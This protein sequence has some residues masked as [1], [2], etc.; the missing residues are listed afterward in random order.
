MLKI[1]DIHTKNRLSSYTKFN[2]F[3]TGDSVSVIEFVHVVEPIGIL[4]SR[5]TQSCLKNIILMIY[6]F[7]YYS[8]D[9]N[10]AF[11][12]PTYRYIG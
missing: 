9:D 5:I 6:E 11:L 1:C 7:N 10:F 2:V 12:I 4:K 3:R 8:R